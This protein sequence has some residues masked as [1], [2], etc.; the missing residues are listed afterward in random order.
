MSVYTQ[1]TAS[2]FAT[3]CAV[4]SVPLSGGSDTFGEWNR[5]LCLEHKLQSLSGPVLSEEEL[6]MAIKLAES[7]IDAAKE[8]IEEAE[9]E[10]AH[11]EMNRQSAALDLN[12]AQ[13]ALTEL[14]EKQRKYI[15]SQGV[16]A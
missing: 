3:A 1:P 14:K 2:R 12:K 8:A 10:I 11:A 15:A 16:I 4:C 6:R 13:T 7:V 5:P 9:D